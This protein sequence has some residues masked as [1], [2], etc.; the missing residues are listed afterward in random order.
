M[1]DNPSDSPSPHGPKKHVP[2]LFSASP[3]S[4]FP[5]PFFLVPVRVVWSLSTF[6]LEVTEHRGMACA[7]D[8]SGWRAPHTLSTRAPRQMSLAERG[9]AASRRKKHPYFF[10]PV[11]RKQLLGGD[12]GFEGR[13]GNR[14]NKPP[15]A[16]AGRLEGV[17]SLEMLNRGWSSLARLLRR[18]TADG[19]APTTD[20]CVRTCVCAEWLQSCPTLCS[21]KDCS[22][23]GSSVHGDSPGRN[24]EVG[25][26]AL[27]Q[28]IFPTQRSN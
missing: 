1:R 21:P 14:Q 2:Q 5:Y 13:D 8:T 4:H 12:V 28:G 26:R 11:I 16:G 20:T 3:C 18:S 9:W 19:A 23:P 27:L 24:T 7:E 22:P 10:A 17:E 25:C 15:K 6:S